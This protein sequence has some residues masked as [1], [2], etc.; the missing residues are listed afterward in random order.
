MAGHG[1]YPWEIRTGGYRIIMIPV[2]D[3]F[4]RRKPDAMHPAFRFCNRIRMLQ[5][6]FM[7]LSSFLAWTLPPCAACWRYCRAIM[8]F[9]S[10]P[11]A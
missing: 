2:L 1:G 3:G 4:F 5:A 9:C 8:L 6:Y 7:V 10:V 11:M